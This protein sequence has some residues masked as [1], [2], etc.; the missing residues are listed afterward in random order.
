MAK[1]SPV[2]VIDLFAGPGG[3]CEG[4]SSIS[5]DSGEK[6]FAVK[7]SI[8]KDP[9][10]HRTLALRALLRQFSKKEVP[11]AYY[12]YVTGKIPEAEFRKHPRI[13]VASEEAAREAKRAELGVTPHNEVDAWIREALGG[14]TNWVLIGGPPCQAYSLAGRSRLRGKDPEKFEADKKHFLYTEYLRIIQQFAPAVFVMENVK[15]MLNSQHGGSR[16]FERILADLRQPSSNLKYQIRSFVVAGDELEP[17]DYVIEADDYG[18]PQSRHRVIL[19]GI[20]SDVAASTPALRDDPRRFLLRKSTKTRTVSEALA[21][22]P[23]LR[24]RL[25]NRS[26]E[27]DSWDAWQAVLRNSAK[28]L[29]EWRD[30]ARKKIEVA[31]ERHVKFSAWHRSH[32]ARFLEEVGD[33]G[34]AMPVGLREWYLDR[35]VGGVLQ[36]ESRSHMASDL[37]RY[38][39]A[40]CFAEEHGVAPRLRQFPPRL[41]PDHENAKELDGGK[42]VPFVDRFRVQ[43]GDKPAAT[44]V[45]HIAKDGHYYIHPDPSQCRSLTVR[46]AARLQTFPD[47]YFFEG[48]RTEQFTQIGNAVP[49][50]LARKLGQVV[51]DLLRAAG[52]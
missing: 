49:P 38:M 22:L 5:E 50:L 46:E 9:V 32:G 42:A 23:S 11:D 26:G 24:S 31:I 45:A 48:N 20:R 21:G 37:H 6:R 39:F 15:G 18:I 14:D 35:R 3:L 36:H 30:P 4:F 44:I 47:N 8:E 2:P 19:L 10:A 17:Q 12:D 7:V 51:S 40:A 29:I 34:D 27:R 52:R 43:L 41:L 33:P 28:G 1:P 16:I 13:K 25:S